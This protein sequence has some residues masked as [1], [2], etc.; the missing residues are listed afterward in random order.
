MGETDPYWGPFNQAAYPVLGVT[1]LSF[2]QKLGHVSFYVFNRDPRSRERL[3][4]PIADGRLRPSE[5]VFPKFL[6]RP[7]RNPWEEQKRGRLTSIMARAASVAALTFWVGKIGGILPPRL[8]RAEIQCHIAR[9]GNIPF[10]LGGDSW[11]SRGGTRCSRVG[12]F[13]GPSC[14]TIAWH[15]GVGPYADH[16]QV[17]HHPCRHVERRDAWASFGWEARRKRKSRN[18]ICAGGNRGSVSGRSGR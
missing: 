11:E 4:A 14:E 17:H 13:I 15:L 16:R 8:A 9:A 5:T 3:G 10:S 1:R 12:G 18:P 7:L 6:R 2:D